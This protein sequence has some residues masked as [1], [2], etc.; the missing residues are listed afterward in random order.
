MSPAPF[1]DIDGMR[2][3]RPTTCHAD[4]APIFCLT[5]VS[6]CVQRHGCHLAGHLRPARRQATCTRRWRRA[7]GGAT[8]VGTTRGARPSG[9][10]HRS[11][12]P[13][14]DC[15]NSPWSSSSRPQ[16]TFTDAPH[17]SNAAAAHDT[18]AAGGGEGGRAAY[19]SDTRMVVPASN[20]IMLATPAN[21][22][23]HASARRRRR[24]TQ[25]GLPEDERRA[26]P[27]GHWPLARR[28]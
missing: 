28:L 6:E 1:G 14:L 20:C 17:L 3:A 22:P 12:R 23:G 27:E 10:A 16:P 2:A 18:A 9:T 26:Q 7:S 25:W 13:R 11:P 24:H 15:E 4:A 5:G 21:E 19:A 8:L